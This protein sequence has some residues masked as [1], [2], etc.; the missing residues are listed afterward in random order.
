MEYGPGSF[1]PGSSIDKAQ[2]AW[3][4][5]FDANISHMRRP[6]LGLAGGHLEQV[7]NYFVDS[8]VWITPNI[9]EQGEYVHMQLSVHG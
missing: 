6:G 7:F 5:V 4:V 1:I 3:Q 9:V 2:G 8:G